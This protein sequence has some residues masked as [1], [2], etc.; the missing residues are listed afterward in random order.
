MMQRN[1]VLKA[2]VAAALGVV[3]GQAGAVVT[4]ASS[5]TAVKFAK[6]LAITSTTTLALSNAANALDVSLPG[7]GSL[8]ATSSAPLYLKLALSNGAKFTAN[9]SVSCSA[10]DASAGNA[11]TAYTGAVTFGG[12]GQSNVTFTIFTANQVGT[13]AAIMSGGAAA[14]VV[15]V[16][17]VT[18]SGSL[19]DVNM[20]ATYEYTNGAAATVSGVSGAYITFARGYSAGATEAAGNLVVDAINGGTRFSA[21]GAAISSA[22]ALLGTVTA[23]SVAGVFA[24]DG[25][26]LLSASDVVATAT[27]TVSGPAIAAALVNGSSG[28]YLSTATNCTANAAVA[29]DSGASSVTFNISTGGGLVTALSAGTLS[30]CA[31]VSGNVSTITTGQITAALTVK[32]GVTNVTADLSAASSNIENITQNGTTMNAYFINASTSTNKT[33]V[34]RI[35]NTNSTSASIRATAY[36]ETGTVLG[37]ASSLLGT[38]AANSML[39]LTSADLESKLGFTPAAATT[40]YRVVIFGN[41][42]GFKVINFVKDVATGNLAL[43]QQQDN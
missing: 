10:A 40:K 6:E 36:S 31:N 15:T 16:N 23:M 14:C 5:P 22:T 34:V 1:L 42:S 25:S 19:T 29:A 20:S 41:V 37:T 2:A 39:T 30:V 12:A 43:G 21:G 7:V 18:V 4:V 24:A 32:T 9:P 13:S 27:L 28:V 38:A 11:A 26:S 35:I 3:A 8:D 17:G 33:S